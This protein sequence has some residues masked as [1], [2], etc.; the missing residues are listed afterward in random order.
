MPFFQELRELSHLGQERRS[1]GRSSNHEVSYFI[2]KINLCKLVQA[3]NL[4]FQFYVHIFP[5]RIHV[6]LEILVVG[7]QEKEVLPLLSAHWLDYLPVSFECLTVR[8]EPT[9][10][11]SVQLKI[12]VKILRWNLMIGQMWLNSADILRSLSHLCFLPKN[13]KNLWQVKVR[14]L[15]LKV[16]I[17]ILSR[18]PF[19]VRILP[20]WGLS[21]HS[22][23]NKINCYKLN[24]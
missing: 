4:G 7:C 6:G 14:I 9:L 20:H 24:P 15:T 17:N 2:L 16:H 1:G 10:F 13:L 11:N 12:V 21:R 18:F 5:N 23:N 8:W 22:H 19:L 3:R